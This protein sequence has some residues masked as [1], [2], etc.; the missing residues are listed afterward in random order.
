MDDMYREM[1]IDHYKNPRNY[2]KVI[3]PDIVKRDSN[4]LC[5]D[6]IELFVKLENDSIKKIGFEGKG[7][8]ICMASTSMLTEEIH[9]KN[10]KHVLNMQR[11]DMLDLIGVNLTASR[12]KCAML[13][14]TCMKKG[15]VEFEEAKK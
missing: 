6:E 5:G 3:N 8:A 15:I 13:G 11:E 9:G 4:P 2:G 10:L 1:I 12:V 14:L 7:C